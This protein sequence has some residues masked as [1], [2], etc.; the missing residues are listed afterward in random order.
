MNDEIYPYLKL[1][2]ENGFVAWSKD[3]PEHEI[4]IIKRAINLG[5]LSESI[6]PKTGRKTGSLR[7]TGKGQKVVD[8]NGNFSVLDSTPTINFSS[9]NTHIGNNSGTY[10]QSSSASDS[11]S[12]KQI[13]I[14]IVATV[15]G[16]LILWLLT[17]L[18]F[19]KI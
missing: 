15:V 14:A 9:Q 18:V 6:N 16:G 4:R 12:V 3:T 1:A 19:T 7:L 5:Y 11:S 13:V 17:E 10:N 8:A 2:D